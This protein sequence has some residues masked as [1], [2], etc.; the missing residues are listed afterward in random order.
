MAAGF[1]V[2]AAAAHLVAAGNQVGM[3]WLATTYLLHTWAELALSAVG[4]S[5]MTR[6]V[7][8]SLLGQSMGLWF[9]SLA[10]GNLLASRIAG[11]FDPAHLPAMPGRFMHI[12]RFGVMCAA[13]LAISL[14]FMRRWMRE[15]P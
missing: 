6:L 3:G 2:M 5:A 10:L 11:N 12:V 8:P 1:L 9:V 15:T 13:G 14:P 7:P 4:M